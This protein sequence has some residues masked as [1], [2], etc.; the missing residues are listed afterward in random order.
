MATV[1]AAGLGAYR[2]TLCGFV[3]QGLG[4]GQMAARLQVEAGV[5]V[6]KTSIRSWLGKHNKD[7]EKVLAECLATGL[8]LAECVD[9]V[10]AMVGYRHSCEYVRKQVVKKYEGTALREIESVAA[11]RPYEALLLRALSGGEAWSDVV[12]ALQV[13]FATHVVLTTSF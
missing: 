2:A 11:L 6:T 7:L 3:E 5:V 9:R 13:F 4:Y 12:E 1:K 10:E 8:M